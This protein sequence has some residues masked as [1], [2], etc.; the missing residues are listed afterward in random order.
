[1]K[2]DEWIFIEVE[3]SV[4]AIIIVVAVLGWWWLLT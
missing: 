1:M 2:L 4:A 3:G